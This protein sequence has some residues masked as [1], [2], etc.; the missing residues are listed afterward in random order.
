MQ[1]FVSKKR[2]Q[3]FR[4]LIRL[5]TMIRIIHYNIIMMI[6][7]GCTFLCT[8]GFRS[9][10]S[11]IIYSRHSAFK[12]LYEL[13]FQEIRRFYRNASTRFHLILWL[14]S[15][16]LLRRTSHRFH[17]IVSE[18]PQ[19]G[20]NWVQV[21]ELCRSL[22]KKAYVE[23]FERLFP[24]K[25]KFYKPILHFKPTCLL[26]FITHMYVHMISSLNAHSFDSQLLV[27]HAHNKINKSF[28]DL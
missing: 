2:P 4:R 8:H 18:S 15:S 22:Q 28:N 17:V 12:I 27:F 1:Q 14:S 19:K 24:Y 7:I 11:V 10:S 6:H 16:I 25:C 26:F 3:D 21:P 23:V 9:L 20:G 5:C 13:E